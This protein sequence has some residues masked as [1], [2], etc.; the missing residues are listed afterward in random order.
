MNN[1]RNEEDKK[2]ILIIKSLIDHCNYVYEKSIVF[3]NKDNF[4]AADEMCG[5]IS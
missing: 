4:L 1:R 5:R 2:V 3:K